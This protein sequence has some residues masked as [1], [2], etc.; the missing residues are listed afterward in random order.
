[1]RGSKMDSYELLRELSLNHGTS[2]YEAEVAKL[3]SEAFKPLSDEVKIDKLGNVIATKRNAEYSSGPRVMLAAHMDEIGLVVTNIEDGGFVRFSTIGGFDQRTLPGQEVV[4][5]GREQL[6]G[7][8]GSKPPHLLSGDERHKSVPIPDLYID[9]GLSDKRC[10]ELVSV[11][12]IAT[13]KRDFLEL[14][15]GIVAGK[16]MDDRAGVAAVLETFLHLDK[17]HGAGANIDS[18]NRSMA[19]FQLFL[20]LG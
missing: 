2:G 16:A 11:G 3:V 8:I 17:L 18:D 5:H 20:S 6:L 4:V 10:R 13:I 1:M 15:K 7:V 9:L 12:D 14:T 19:F